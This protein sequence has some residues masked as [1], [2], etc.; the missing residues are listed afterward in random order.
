M[1]LRTLV[2][3]VWLIG[4]I[5]MNSNVLL[6]H[7]IETGIKVFLGSNIK[8]FLCHQRHQVVKAKRMF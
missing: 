2:E 8:E 5:A 4:P 7:A 3:L 6:I 1:F